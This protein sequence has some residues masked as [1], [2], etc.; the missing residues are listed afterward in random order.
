MLQ[1]AD[2][3]FLVN[4]IKERSDIS[5]QYEA[6]LLAVDSDTQ[7]VQRVMRAAPR[8]EP[9]RDA[10]EVFLVDRVQHRGHRPLDNL[11]FQGSDRERALSS[12]R[13]E[14][15]NAPARQRPVHSP[16]DPVVQVLKLALEV[17]LVVRPRQSVHTRGG[18]LI[19]FV[20]RLFQQ[21]DADVVEK[22]S[23]LLLLPFL[24][25]FPY[26]SQRLF[27][28]Y[29][30]L[31]PARALLFRISL[32]PSPSLHRLRCARLCRCLHSK[33]IRFVRRLHRYYGG[34]RLLV[35]VHHRL[36]LLAFPMRTVILGTMHA[37]ATA[38]PETSQVP[39][40]SLC[41]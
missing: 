29:P 35:S 4:L 13:L 15:V 7:R 3:P 5:V 19:K 23:E 28:A 40:R 36:R 38:R 30:V 27:H 41:T 25:G 32:G 37:T 11:V 21:V 16:M 26:A 18:V 20:E 12:V 2:Q 8:P 22:C 14:Y 31:R 33:L 6:H 9:V 1:K 24:C 39:I 17:C 10:E 34:V